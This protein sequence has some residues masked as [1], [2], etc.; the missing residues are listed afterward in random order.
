[1]A[2]RTVMPGDIDEYAG[3]VHLVTQV[4]GTTI[5]TT[6]RV[7]GDFGWVLAEMPVCHSY[8]WSSQYPTFPPPIP[9]KSATSSILM[10][11]F[12]IL[13]PN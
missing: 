2:P 12:A 5:Q 10:M 3:P 8:T 6:L 11:Y 9:L 4:E 1:V 7:G 13:Y